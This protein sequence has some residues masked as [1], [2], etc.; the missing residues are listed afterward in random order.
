MIWHQY[1]QQNS[2][3]TY[4]LNIHKSTPKRLE[5]DWQKIKLNR[6]DL[7]NAFITH[8]KNYKQECFYLEIG[9]N[10]DECFNNVLLNN[11]YKTGVDPL[12]GG[13][14]RLTSDDFFST[15]NKKF[16]VIF[17]DG[18]HE[19]LQVQKD[20]IN[21]LNCLNDDG[22]IIIHDMLPLSWEQECVPRFYDIW[23]GDVW[24]IGVEIM[25]SENLNFSI[26]SCDQGIGILK[27]NNNNFNYRRMNNI[28]AQLSY[29]DF[30]EDFFIKLPI[31]SENQ[32][33]INHY[34]SEK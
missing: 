24:K 19:Y 26:I 7:I 3:K 29:K 28:L 14:L 10:D 11:D 27:K 21:S 31:L 12:K 23:N 32:F 34:F 17:I 16:D 5:F 30:L 18:L 9:C 22:V 20:C 1:F 2:L 8:T 4:Y 33:N 15:N 25:H 6:I 13:N